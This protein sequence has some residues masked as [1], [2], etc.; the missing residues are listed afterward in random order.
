M[1]E[2]VRSPDAWYPGFCRSISILLDI[3]YI[4]CPVDPVSLHYEA[5]V[6]GFEQSAPALEKTEDEPSDDTRDEEDEE[7]E[8]KAAQ[9]TFFGGL[10]AVIDKH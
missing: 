4:Y 8:E 2:T 6:L 3:S 9:S 10:N 1:S 7:Q 5:Y